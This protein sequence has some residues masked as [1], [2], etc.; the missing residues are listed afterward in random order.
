LYDKGLRTGLFFRN[1]NWIS[2][3]SR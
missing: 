1:C 2:W 3:C